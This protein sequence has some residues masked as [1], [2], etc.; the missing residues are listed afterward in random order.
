MKLF[1]LNLGTTTFKIG[2]HEVKYEG[3]VDS[4]G[5]AFGHGT[6]TSTSGYKAT[7]T[8]TFRDN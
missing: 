3:L 7:W 8:G 1:Y 6:A 5:R 4:N 2:G